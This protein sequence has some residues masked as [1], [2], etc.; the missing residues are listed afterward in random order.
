MEG[1]IATLRGRQRVGIDTSVFI[2]H[3][4]SNSRYADIVAAVFQE[5]AIGSFEAITSVLTL[6]ELAVRPLQLKRPDIAD[7]YDVILANF[8]NLGIV[9]IDRA[10][11]RRAAE[12]R[13]A[14]RLR[15]A[16]ALQVSASI[17]SSASSFL[18]NDLNLRRISEID[19]LLLDD[20]VDSPHFR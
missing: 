19:I 13:A 20:Y 1:L 7:E 10:V 9:P 18:S 6:M 16:D 15:P 2:Y 8:P 4:E 17:E 5:M 3:L 12:L 14:Y 11:A